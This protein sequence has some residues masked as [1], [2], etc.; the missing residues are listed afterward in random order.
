MAVLPAGT[1]FGGALA[2]LR[3]EPWLLDD[4]EYGR[5]VLRLCRRAGFEPR[6]AGHLVSHDAL[7][8]AI[9]CGLGVT[10]LP[11][12]A[13]EHVEGVSVHPLEPVAHRELL[14]LHHEL[15]RRSVALTLDVLIATARAV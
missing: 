4:T 11:T 2:D 8:Y 15:G 1:A 5:H 7:L 6:L 9:R 10:V 14:V 13:L 3:D 12:F